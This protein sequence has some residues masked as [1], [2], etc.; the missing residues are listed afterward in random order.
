MSEVSYDDK[1]ILEYHG[2]QGLEMLVSGL[3]TGM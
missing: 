1:Y 2:R 3:A